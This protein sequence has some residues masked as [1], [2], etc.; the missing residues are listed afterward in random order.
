MR[1]GDHSKRVCFVLGALDYRFPG[2]QSRPIGIIIG[3]GDKYARGIGSYSGVLEKPKSSLRI[4][5][6]N[7]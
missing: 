6:V 3:K 2:G 1:L 5:E 4:I 7:I